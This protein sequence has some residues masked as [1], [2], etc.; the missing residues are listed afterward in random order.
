MVGWLVAYIGLGM[1]TGFFA[2]MLGIGGG[3]VM[4]PVLVWMFTAQEFSNS[5]VLHLAL[6]TSMATILFTAIA[7]VRAHHQHGAVRW[8]VVQKMT[9][10]VLLGTALGTS[11]ARHIPLRGLVIFF[12]CFTLLIA[13]QM[14]LN[15]KPAPQRQLPGVAGQ[16]LIASL[17]GLVSSLVAVGGGALTVPYLSGCNVP[18]HRAIGTSAALGMPIALGGSLGY[19]VNGWAVAGLPGATLGFIYL[20]AVA[21]LVLGSSVTAPLGAKTAHR[22]PVLTLKRIFAGLL[23]LLS[24][25]MMRALF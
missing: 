11:L 8:D 7:S 1:F 17:I 21:G 23:V 9:L 10:G 25:K 15:F 12:A 4:V 3:L 16:T 20:P 6:G 2:G 22:L 19:M 18:V 5:H 14:A 13:L 24:I